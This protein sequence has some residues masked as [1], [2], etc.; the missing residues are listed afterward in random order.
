[1]RFKNLAL[2]KHINFYIRNIY[3]QLSYIL[4]IMIVK[5]EIYLAFIE[6]LMYSNDTVLL[7]QFLK[8]IFLI[9]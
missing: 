8:W 7:R 5:F 4:E 1:M 9:T 2:L 6:N 3:I